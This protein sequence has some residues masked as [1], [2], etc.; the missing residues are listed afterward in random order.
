MVEGKVCETFGPT[1]EKWKLSA[2]PGKM[3]RLEFLVNQLGL[4]KVS[5]IPESIRYQLLHRA[6]SAV[7]EAKRFKANHAMMI[8]HS[9]SQ[10]NLWFNDFQAFLELF[11][12]TAI[13][14]QLVFVCRTQEVNF[15]CGWAKGNKK[16]LFNFKPLSWEW[17]WSCYPWFWK[18]AGEAAIAT[19]PP[20]NP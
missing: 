3:K 18:L 10:E 7:I 13:P 19:A 2:S 8:V 5:D 11:Q 15:Y 4:P 6:V 14:G 1:I 12:V 9:F 16:Y 20:L 17:R